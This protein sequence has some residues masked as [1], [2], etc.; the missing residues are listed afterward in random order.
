[1]AFEDSSS[2]NKGVWEFGGKIRRH[3][4]VY[5]WVTSEKDFLDHGICLLEIFSHWL[6][7]RIDKMSMRKGTAWHIAGDRIRLHIISLSCHTANQK[8]QGQ[9]RVQ[10][11]YHSPS[12]IFWDLI[13]SKYLPVAHC[14]CYPIQIFTV[15]FHST[16]YE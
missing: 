4:L 12:Q 6:K 15:A 2:L 10:N 5:N 1:M 11:L 7:V 14:S 16:I 9:V 13:P 8:S 3:D